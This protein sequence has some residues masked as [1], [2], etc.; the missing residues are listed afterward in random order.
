MGSPRDRATISSWPFELVGSSL[1]TLGSPLT[2]LLK[3]ALALAGIG[4]VPA[5]L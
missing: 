5:S 2:D 1:D 4:Q 3:K